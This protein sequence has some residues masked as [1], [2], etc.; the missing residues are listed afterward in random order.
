M[1]RASSAVSAA[2]G[3]QC[4]ENAHHAGQVLRLKLGLGLDQ[5][6]IDTVDKRDGV[7]A[8][9]AV[10]RVVFINRVAELLTGWDDAEIHDRP[11]TEVFPLIDQKS[12]APIDDPVSKVVENGSITSLPE[13]VVLLCRDGSELAIEDSCAPVLDDEGAVTGVVLV[14]RDIT[15][16]QRIEADLLNEQKLDSIGIAGRPNVSE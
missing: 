1:R 3:A 2:Q 10:G 5:A 6:R 16:K 15:Q 7:I 14:F 13:N 4:V 11:F 9:D 8:T 12:R